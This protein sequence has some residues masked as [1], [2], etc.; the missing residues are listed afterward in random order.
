MSQVP[1]PTHVSKSQHEGIVPTSEPQETINIWLIVINY[2]ILVN[3]CKKVFTGLGLRVGSS[4]L[5]D[6][7]LSTSLKPRV[8]K[9]VAMLA[10][11]SY[12]RF[13][14]WDLV[15]SI[16]SQLPYS[17]QPRLHWLISSDLGLGTSCE[18]ALRPHLQHRRLKLWCMNDFIVICDEE[19][20][21]AQEEEEELVQCSSSSTTTTT[22]TTP[23]V[24]TVVELGRIF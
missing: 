14:T 17:Q 23:T 18:L 12:L 1:S 2:R 8:Q 15:W 20:E 21:E 10:S 13:R 7:T 11:M 19:E 24:T 5:L 22:T 3:F 9:S 4:F 6:R 16:K